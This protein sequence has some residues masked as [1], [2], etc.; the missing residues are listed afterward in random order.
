MNSPAPIK[1]KLLQTLALIA[2]LVAAKA[3]ATP[4]QTLLKDIL[5]SHPDMQMAEA[6]EESAKGDVKAARSGY[7]PTLGVQAGIGENNALAEQRQITN[8]PIVVG[9]LPLYD[10]GKTGS[11]VD[12]AKENLGAATLKRDVVRE[13]LASQLAELYS[14]ALRERNAWRILEKESAA[15]AV[16]VGKIEQISKIDSGRR[17]EFVQVTSRYQGIIQQ[18][19][20]RKTQYMIL[21]GRLR[22]FTDNP[23]LELDEEL[24]LPQHPLLSLSESELVAL[25]PQTPRLAYADKSLQASM[26]DLDRQR[27]D[28]YPSFRLTAQYGPERAFAGTYGF[29][30][31]SKPNLAVGINVNMPLF[32]GGL[33]R[34][35]IAVAKG[36]VAQSDAQQAGTLRELEA[37]VRAMRQSINERPA[38]IETL[39]RQAAAAQEMRDAAFDQFLVGR[40]SLTDLLTFEA[41]VY[42]ALL[43][44]SDESVELRLSTYRLLGDG[45]VLAQALMDTPLAAAP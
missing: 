6:Q 1:P 17:F 12:F 40:R 24:P 16:M 36:R 26:A 10:F 42:Q 25:L 21:L 3:H 20:A 5:S 28:T 39:G 41:D 30:D 45:G 4:M 13:Q 34:G 33:N 35:R 8:A 15:F 37:D 38:R 11:S 44:Q 32:D 2:A 18:A 43:A 23:G 9:A 29:G 22:A 14:N 7:M 31:S 27:H 19:Q